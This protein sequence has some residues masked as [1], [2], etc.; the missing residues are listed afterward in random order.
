MLR[1]VALVAALIDDD[2]LS[3]L[4][5]PDACLSHLHPARG[6]DAQVRDPCLC[7]VIKHETIVDRTEVLVGIMLC[8]DAE[9]AIPVI[10]GFVPH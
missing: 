3:E 4:F 7:V 2:R 10:Q 9:E 1:D 5:A 6:L 8:Y